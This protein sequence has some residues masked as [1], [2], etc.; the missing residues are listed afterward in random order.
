MAMEDFVREITSEWK[1]LSKSERIKRTKKLCASPNTM[2]FIQ[3]R[4]PE[5]YAE[6]FPRA[7]T[8]GAGS[9]E[10]SQPHALCAK[11]L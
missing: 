8:W 9:S 6:A 3:E 2:K 5:F 1:T 4:F 10:S 11:P 7:R